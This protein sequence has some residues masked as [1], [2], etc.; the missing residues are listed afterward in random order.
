MAKAEQPRWKQ[1]QKH[2]RE[3]IRTPPRIIMLEH[4]PGLQ[5][6]AMRRRLVFVSVIRDGVRPEEIAQQSVGTRFLE[7]VELGEGLLVW[8]WDGIKADG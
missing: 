3:K 1:E 5:P 6:R 2:P 4:R 7:S 8:V